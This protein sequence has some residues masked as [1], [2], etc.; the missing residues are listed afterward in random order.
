MKKVLWYLVS[1]AV[2]FVTA[3]WLMGRLSWLVSDNAEGTS[4][5]QAFSQWLLEKEQWYL[6]AEYWL[7]LVI[8]G[9]MA[10][11][12]LL[13]LLSCKLDQFWRALPG[14]G[15]WEDQ[16]DESP[17]EDYW[18]LRLLPGMIFFAYILLRIIGMIFFPQADFAIHTFSMTGEGYSAFQWISQGTYF[19]ILAVTVFLMLDSFVSAGW[20]GAVPHMLAVLS[21]NILSFVLAFVILIS[22]LQALPAAIGVV[23]TVAVVVALFTATYRVVYVYYD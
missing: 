1:A 2:S 20:I 19:L 10:L 23:L 13:L 22:L 4:D 14:G 7:K 18:W 9:G 5:W 8:A 12:V 17:F 15:F 16:V 3:G 21:A 11:V 6:G